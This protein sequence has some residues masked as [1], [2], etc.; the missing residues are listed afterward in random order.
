MVR[1]D[2]CLISTN[3]KNTESLCPECL[4]RIP[5]QRVVQGETVYLVKRCPE[6]GEYRTLLWRG[7][8]QWDS[9]LRPTIPTPPR[10]CFTQVERGCPFDCGLCKEHYKTTCTA[11]LEVT[12]RCNL[13]CRV[14]FANAG[15]ELDEPSLAVIEGWYKK[16]LAA[17]GPVNIQLS[18]GEPTLRN[19]LPE[20][21]EM[22]RELGFNFIQLNTNGL[23]LAEDP[24]FVR[25]LKEA[26]LSSVFLQFDGTED[27]I[28]Q[29]IRGRKLLEVKAKAIESCARHEIGVVLVPT[30][31][32]G[33]NTHNIG[34]ILRFALENHPS[35]RGVHFQP[36]SY[37]G[38]IL[39]EPLDSDRITLPEVIQAIEEQTDGLIKA[40]SLKPHNGRCSFSGNFIRQTD[41]SMQP[42][43]N[44]SCCNG[45]ERA[46]ELARKTRTFVAR[47]WSGAETSKNQPPS[48]NS[49]DNIIR[50]L[51]T[52][53]FS[54]SGM[55]F[56]DVWNLDIERLKNCCIHVVSP[57]GKLIPFCAYNLT[58]KLGH[59]IYR[60]E[61]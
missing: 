60:R 47:Q 11:L 1:I 9:W 7:S 56:Q 41:G 46:D 43:I 54:I 34:G 17:S 33:I 16:V 5:A 55:A 61:R 27:S 8:P 50:Q 23:R 32:P 31:I 40:A 28:Y 30:L 44:N 3:E 10:E 29:T 18:G 45:P 53:A 48:T 26:G 2:E 20:I 12:Q 37:F 14:C 21:V 35:V 15:T 51:K 39:K 38:R 36:V 24:G 6:H 52:Y 57:E 49:W 59:P 58:D 42:V 4:Q 22:G 19:D 13:N 25:E